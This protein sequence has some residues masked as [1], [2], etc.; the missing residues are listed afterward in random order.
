MASVSIEAREGGHRGFGYGFQRALPVGAGYGYRLQAQSGSGES[1]LAEL[2]GQNRYGRLQARHSSFGGEH[3]SSVV[4]SG[5][6]AVIGGTLQA[7]RSID[8]AF[9]LIRVPGQPGVR[10]YVAGQPVGKTD[11]QGNLLVPNLLSYNENEIGIATEDIPLDASIQMAQQVVVPARR[12]GA[13][14]TFAATRIRRFQGRVRLFLPGGAPA[15]PAFG[16]MTLATGE[17]SP[18]GRDGEFYFENLQ[19]GTLVAQ[20]NHDDRRY[21]CQIVVPAGNEAS[22]T[23]EPITCT[24]IEETR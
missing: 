15:V 2:D 22:V 11:E 12:G 8:D 18:L 4:A 16:E 3:R 19:P 1:L 5:S 23:L 7:T 21:R 14:V 6:V 17:S 10:A 9:G 24:V 13:I 20:V